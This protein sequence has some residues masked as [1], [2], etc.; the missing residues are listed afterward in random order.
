MHVGAGQ[1]RVRGKGPTGQR[2]AMGTPIHIFMLGIDLCL[3]SRVQ[4]TSQLSFLLLSAVCSSASSS[5]AVPG[6]DQ[7]LYLIST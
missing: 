4:A 1:D 5:R 3:L 6:R 2:V 7:N